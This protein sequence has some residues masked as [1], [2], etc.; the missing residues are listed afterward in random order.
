ML[1]K[2]VALF[3]ALML[4][5][6]LFA[7]CKKEVQ[8]ASSL[9]SNKESSIPLKDTS[10][11]SGN[12]SVIEILPEKQYHLHRNSF[13]SVSENGDLFYCGA[14][15]G[16][17]KQLADDK[18]ISKIYSGSGY[19]FFSVDCLD[20]DRICVGF[21]SEKLESSYIIFNL[22][23]KTV[24]NAVSGDEFK[25][26]SIHQLLHHDGAVFFLANPDRYG[27]YTLYTQKDGVT[28]PLVS[29]VN[30]FFIWGDNIFY[31][32]GNDIY[33]LDLK[34]EPATSELVGEA[35]YSYLSGFTI[36][37]NT[38]FYSTELNTYFTNFISGNFGKLPH[39]L[40]V[41]TGT[42]HDK[43]AFFCGENGGIYA[44][45]LESGIITKVSDYTAGG[46]QSA[47]GYLYLSP[48]SSEHSPDVEKDYLIQD[49]IYRFPAA[50]L[51]S[52]IESQNSESESNS[53]S[54]TSSSLSQ[55]ESV[56]SSPAVEEKEP[57][58]PE[59]F[60]R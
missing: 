23:D 38:L 47:G 54:L 55:S 52:Q 10:S 29:G 59:K 18:G 15:G 7:S 39:K 19:E 49:G 34:T 9:S 35:E 31:N 44:V 50:A 21:K 4:T 26:K 1:K 56:S 25:D 36:V 28:K 51:I 14:T 27:R 2:S 42:R 57:L 24:E 40:N 6:A 32:I 37:G 46:L 41:W 33:A 12:N 43:Y 48:A 13:M 22:K 45:N 5:C 30:E 16:I 60:G 11:Q 53:S 20:L 17:Y 58:K 3:L 8:G